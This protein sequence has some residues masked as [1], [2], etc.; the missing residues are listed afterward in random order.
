M[1]VESPEG[2]REERSIGKWAGTL[3]ILLG[4]ILSVLP[5]VA[6]GVSMALSLSQEAQLASI[7]LG[8]PLAWV[9]VYLLMSA[10]RSPRYVLVLLVS[11]PAFLCLISYLIAYVWV[12]AE[13]SGPIFGA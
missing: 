7:C 6:L 8:L 4:L 11:V 9:V 13:Y 12:A 3:P 10:V 1:I 5:L 2:S